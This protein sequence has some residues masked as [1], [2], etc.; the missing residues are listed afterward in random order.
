MATR[1]VT[2]GLAA[3][4]DQQL[5]PCRLS[6]R[7]ELASAEFWRWRLVPLSR[8]GRGGGGCQDTQRE[9]VPRS[10]GSHLPARRHPRIRRAWRADREGCPQ[11]LGNDA[12]RGEASKG[13]SRAG[14]EPPGRSA[15]ASPPL[16]QDPA[17]LL[18]AGQPRARA[19]AGGRFEEA[20]LPCPGGIGGRQGDPTPAG[21]RHPGD[22]GQVRGVPPLRGQAGR[23]RPRVGEL[24][25][26]GSS[27]CHPPEAGQAWR[28]SRR[29][30]QE[31]DQS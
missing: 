9:K 7:V 6:L 16:S 11:Q 22:P 24:R 23:P 4:A 31:E 29:E 18:P 14:E 13:G 21:P 20:P 3:A 25:A 19:P 8:G 17:A 26:R 27:R 1:L 30:G 15:V 10:I 12:G 5:P 2:L 28:R